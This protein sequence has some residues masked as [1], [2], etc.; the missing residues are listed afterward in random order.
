MTSILFNINRY[1]QIDTIN[2]SDVKHIKTV[3]ELIKESNKLFHKVNREKNLFI[4]T[5]NEIF[6]K[7]YVLEKLSDGFF[8]RTRVWWV[9]Y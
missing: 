1:S 3:K 2:K 8:K 7:I 4:E 9:D 6:E 5:R